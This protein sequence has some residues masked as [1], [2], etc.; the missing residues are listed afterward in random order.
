[1][2]CRFRTAELGRSRHFHRRVSPDRL[3]RCLGFAGE[4]LAGHHASSSGRRG[5]LPSRSL[6]SGRAPTEWSCGGNPAPVGWGRGGA[7]VYGFELYRELSL[8]LGGALIANDA[9]ALGASVRWQHLRISGYGSVSGLSL[10]AGLRIALT[11]GLLSTATL[12]SL[13]ATP[14][15]S[16]RREATPGDPLGPCCA[17]QP[18]PPRRDR[19]GSGTGAIR[20]GLP[21]GWSTGRCLRWPFAAVCRPSPQN[22]RL[23]SAFD[24]RGSRLTTASSSM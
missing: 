2:P 23:A 18:A 1:M 24:S 14:L 22:I 11:D 3:G 5:L 10:D 16:D 12:S 6:R 7:T 21:P 9:L 20:W 13:L 8:A 17:A 4:S 19:V 15:G